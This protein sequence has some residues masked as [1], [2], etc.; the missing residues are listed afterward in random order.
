MP[1]HQ[2][3]LLWAWLMTGGRAGGGIG[4][5]AARRRL[6]AEFGM[7]VS[8]AA[9]STLCYC[10]PATAGRARRDEDGHGKPVVAIQRP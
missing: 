7:T 2:K 4:V 9:L 5:R 6:A 8:A 3:Q 10:Y 1:L